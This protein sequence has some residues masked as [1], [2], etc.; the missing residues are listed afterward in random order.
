V[1][2]DEIVNEWSVPL[3][4]LPPSIESPAEDED[5]QI[6]GLHDIEPMFQTL[7]YECAEHLHISSTPNFALNIQGMFW[8]F[9]DAQEGTEES[10]RAAFTLHCWEE[11][12][13]GKSGVFRFMLPPPAQSQ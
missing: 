4:S 5:D 11:A 3:N 8:V 9:I 13:K 2:V 6:R 1:H 12:M 10:L 7:A